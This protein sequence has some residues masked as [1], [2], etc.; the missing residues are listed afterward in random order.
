MYLALREDHP[1]AGRAAVSVHDLGETPL[2]LMRRRVWPPGHDAVVDWVRAQVPDQRFEALATSLPSALGLVAAGAGAYI[3]P[4]SALIAQSGLAF[5]P[6]L[7]AVAT[8]VLIH[9]PGEPSDAEQAVIDAAAAIAA[10]LER[11]LLSDPAHARAIA[12][13][14]A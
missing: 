7:N 4:S 14:Q 2:V 8:V 3:L 11:P 5:V 10:R 12:L 1:L 9:R 6:L 13:G